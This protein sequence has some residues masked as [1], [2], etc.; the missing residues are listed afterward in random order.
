MKYLKTYE[1]YEKPKN[2]YWKVRT[3]TPYF[4]ISLDKMGMVEDEKL[5]YIQM[6]DDNNLINQEYV[7][8]ALNYDINITG[9]IGSEFYYDNYSRAFDDYEYLGEIE[10]EITPEDIEEWHLKNDAKRYN[11]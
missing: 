7:Y 6:R 9:T 5:D 10:K 1:S 4:E 11:L 2:C 8:V 3:D